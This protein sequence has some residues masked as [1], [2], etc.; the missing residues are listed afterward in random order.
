MMNPQNTSLPPR[1]NHN[2]VLNR[3]R[4]NRA[5]NF[6]SVA[7][8]ML[9]ILCW[10]YALIYV[11]ITTDESG[12]FRV[13]MNNN[14]ESILLTE[15]LVTNAANRHNKNNGI[16][17]QKSHHESDTSVLPEALHPITFHDCCTPAIM[18]GTAH[19]KDLQCFGTC[20]NQRACH[21]PSYPYSSQE[22]RE[23][24]GTLVKYKPNSLEANMTKRRCFVE[25]QWLEP[26]VTWCSK[27]TRNETVYGDTPSP[28]CSILSDAQGGPWQ[29]VFVFPRAKLAFCGIPKG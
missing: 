19:P 2:L 11:W 17:A 27:P 9:M 8:C 7:K 22:E 12:V 25:P 15:A 26:N 1:Q 18:N 14:F 3:S 20:Y 29:H 6:I 28:G 16:E 23:T 4:R 21:D 10:T 5:R 13:S 24:F